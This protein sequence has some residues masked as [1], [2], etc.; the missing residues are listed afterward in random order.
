MAPDHPSRIEAGIIF[1]L[2]EMIQD[3]HVYAPREMLTGRA[4]ELLGV[5]PDLIPSGL[6]RLIQAE[7]IC[8]EIIP[9]LD[10]PNEP[11]EKV[12]KFTSPIWNSSY[13]SYSAVLRRK[14]RG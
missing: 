8:P 10:K 4:V 12:A 2:N 11:G 9:D 7:R 6:E 13:L 1:A 14:R 3:G 5:S